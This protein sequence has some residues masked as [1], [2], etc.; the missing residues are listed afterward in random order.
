MEN[1]VAFTVVS[2][3]L[4]DA[5]DNTALPLSKTFSLDG[6]GILQKST[7][8]RLVRGRAQRREV[9]CA[10]EFAAL[11][12]T[13]G[14]HQALM[15]GIAEKPDV[16]I[17]ASSELS[18]NVGAIARTKKD[19]RYR[20]GPGVFYI[21]Y[22]PPQ[23]ST[24]LRASEIRDALVRACPDLATAPT[25]AQA[26][27]SSCIYHE[28]QEIQGARGWHFYILVR[29]A[30][31]IERA[32]KVLYE[33]LWLVGEGRF[34][35]SASGTLL[36]RTLA[37]ASVWQ[38]NR[39]DFS[40]AHCLPP[41]SQRRP[42]PTIWNNDATLFDT[43]LIGELSVA[44]KAVTAS[45]RAIA[46]VA[47][48][49]KRRQV[50]ETW[51]ATSAQKLVGR[52]V[53]SAIAERTARYAADSGALLGDFELID[54][55]GHTLTVGELL[56]DKQ[57]YHGARFHD[58]LEPEYRGDARIAIANLFGGRPI[59]YSHAHGGRKYYLYPQ[60]RTLQI[61]KGELPRIA[62]D[63]LAVL[64]IHG[65][66][67]D[68]PT[69]KG[70]HQLVYVS[71]RYII[72]ITEAWLRTYLGRLFRCEKF[73]KRTNCWEP[74]DVPKELVEAITSNTT[75]RGLNILEAVVEEPSMRPDGSIL[76]EPGY[77]ARDRVLFETGDNTGTVPRIPDYPTDEQVRDAFS[78][79]W[80]PFKEFP[81]D[82]DCSR[83]V[84]VAALLTTAC[85]ATIDTAPGFAFDAP[86]AA[87]GKTLLAQCIAYL[88][89]VLPAVEAPP[90]TDEEANKKLF[91]SLRSGAPAILWDNFTQPIH[92]NSALCSFL[93]APIFA[94]RVLGVSKS[95]SLP[96]K[97]IL[98]LTG[99]N[100]KIE[101]DACR[102]IL[103]CRIDAQIERPGLR[104]FSVAPAT[105]VKE[106]CRELRAAALTLMR[107]YF[108]RGAIR[109][110][111]NT[112]GS[113]ETWDRMT[114]QCVVWLGKSGF[115]S[116]GLEDPYKSALENMDQD[117]QEEI[118]LNVMRAW[119]AL[120]GSEWKSAGEVLQVND[121][122]ED[123]V[124]SSNKT[125][126]LAAIAGIDPKGLNA[127]RLGGWL[128]QHRDEIISG[129]RIIARRDSVSK[130]WRYSVERV[131]AQQSVIEL[132]EE[133][134]AT[135]AS[136]PSLAEIL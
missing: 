40:G 97:A 5:L 112:A 89:G 31:D 92:G 63:V 86:R 70:Q 109:Q 76:D 95:E 98:L 128:Q 58:P 32:G 102:R 59:L 75:S 71:G 34:E 105:Y 62:D 49:G 7:H 126:L 136:N 66:L 54:S 36:D 115:A 28:A 132:S 125:E 33:R 20:S 16:E 93:T 11:L 120:F 60:T 64:R 21:D 44:E 127:R 41:L 99:N 48:E 117:P 88:C 50:R 78:A 83:G 133:S 23:G 45:N 47:V 107:G 56:A 82:N 113:F 72:P 26:S 114:R 110:S 96:N 30:G 9:G 124:S 101:G 103:K 3:A 111:T 10:A 129:L 2:N 13:L 74:A 81:F 24:P 131:D 65:D 1:V 37:D 35:I 8:A 100:L 55:E 46:K 18:N 25:I 116:V 68:Q 77:S 79:L 42:P 15:Y 121:L 12:Q 38:A 43:K 134:L 94:S 53:V 19:V 17:V 106:N 87:S 80:H 104:S 84:M 85:R 4:T 51:V 27:T 69:G 123:G 52:G 29:D 118:V 61:Q 119:R 57:K 14:P 108:S 90:L 122:F 22:D 39:L 6:E 130:N 67:F 73:D 135:L 91:A